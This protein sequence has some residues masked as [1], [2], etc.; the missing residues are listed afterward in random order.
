M[1]GSF[2]WYELMTHDAD[3]AADFYSK[4][5][6]WD[7]KDS[8]MSEATTGGMAYT[9][10]S[11]PG[12]PMGVAGLMALT[13]EMKAD[14][15]PPNWSGYV[16]VDDVDAMVTRFV[17]G[18]GSTVVPATDIPEI[19]R[20]AV[21]ADPHGAVINVMKPIPPAGGMPPEPPENA[22]GTFGWR[23]LLAG[24]AEEDFEFYS[25]MFGWQKDMA[26]DMGAM[27]VYQTFKLDGPAIGGMMTKVPEMPMAY[28]GY[29]VNV[30][31]IDA[32]AE[33]VKTGGGQI[34]NGPHEVPGGAWI[35][36]CVDPQG[37]YFSLVSMKR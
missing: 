27:G 5:V 4:V 37:A 24:N 7:A 1:Q 32:A 9:V 13:D 25:R 11:V 28:W 10:F 6:G 30:E 29:Y 35:I 18:G 36:N 23:E 17:A 34:V 31:A 16:A 22:P 2:I 8:G 15:I 19:G 14:G 20:F 33:R 3:A 26:V 21:L 12:F